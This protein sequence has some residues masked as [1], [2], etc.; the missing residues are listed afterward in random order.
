MSGEIPQITHKICKAQR[1]NVVFSV[2]FL[3]RN[4]G[5]QFSEASTA[6]SLKHI[7]FKTFRIA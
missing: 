1:D 3:L 6:N 5:I 4:F 2:S 7:H